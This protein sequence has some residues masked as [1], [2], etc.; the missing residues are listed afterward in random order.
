MSEA[1][2]V[3][4][5]P[6]AGIV[7]P[8]VLASMGDLWKLRSERRRNAR[9]EPHYLLGFRWLALRQGVSPRRLMRTRTPRS[10]QPCVDAAPQHRQSQ[11]A[12][13]RNWGPSTS[14]RCWS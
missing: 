6:W 13:W 14:R 8:A 7:L 2:T 4:I 12:A 1:T 11:A 5:V 3:Q 9:K 10:R